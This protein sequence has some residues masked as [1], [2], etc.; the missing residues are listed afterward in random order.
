MKIIASLAQA[1]Q[2][3]HPAIGALLHTAPARV[4]LALVCS[5]VRTFLEHGHDVVPRIQ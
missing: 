3:S 2:R 1:Q 4:Q 5:T